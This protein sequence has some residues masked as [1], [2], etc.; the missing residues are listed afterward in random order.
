MSDIAY[1]LRIPRIEEDRGGAARSAK[2]GFAH[3][4]LSPG[5]P[6][7]ARE[8]RQGRLLYAALGAAL[9]LHL[10]VV[11]PFFLG[12]GPD[13]PDPGAEQ[14][15]PDDL[16]VS[17]VSEADLQ[18]FS[19]PFRQEGSRPSTVQQPSPPTPEQA[20]AI[21]TPPQSAAQEE[22]AEPSSSIPLAEGKSKQPF[23]PEGFIAMASQQ[24]A[25]QINQ[26][27]DASA[28]K[29][30]E[31]AR[32]PVAAS[33]GVKMFRPG[34]AHDGKSD[35]F[36]RAVYWALAATKPMGNGKYGSTIVTFSISAAGQLEGLKL[37]HSS[38]DNWLDQGALM[39]VRQAK[40]PVPPSG[41]GAGDR[42]FSVE[43]ISLEGR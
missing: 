17:V 15:T 42:T 5:E 35:E 34:A 29:R 43:Y 14:G 23:D 28:A 25:S 24:F 6:A 32:R 39:A 37:V 16:N 9:L 40:L 20:E 27:F 13:T 3:L 36:A 12:F 11:A 4:S 1:S 7:L 19:D 30:R 38:G 33:G 18:R 8:P 22:K 10:L 2:P 26:A 41:I 21:P 31:E